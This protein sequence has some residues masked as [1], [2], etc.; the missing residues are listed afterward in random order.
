MIESPP[1]YLVETRQRYI[2]VDSFVSSDY[3]L[4]R[5]MPSIENP[6]SF[7]GK[8]VTRIGDAYYE[9]Q[10][11]SKQVL[12]KTGKSLGVSASDYNSAVEQMYL[13]AGSEADRLGLTLGVALT[14]DEIN[15]LQSDIIWMENRKIDGLDVLVP[16][17]YVSKLNASDIEQ[18]GLVARDVSVQ[19]EKIFNKGLIKAD[20]DVVV[21][22]QGDFINEGGQVSSGRLTRI[23]TES[24][25]IMN[26]TTVK[27]EGRP[28]NFT[29]SIDR[30]ASIQSEGSVVLESGKNI[31]SY[32]GSISAADHLVMAADKTLHYQQWLL[33][34]N[35]AHLV[36]IGAIFAEMWCIKERMLM[37]GGIL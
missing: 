3:F 2:D 15:K 36:E 9:R 8:K 17:V 28:G 20:Q 23:R 32:G 29:D 24:G 13:N 7:E 4:E 26:R 33:N 10:L 16:K 31:E 34:L 37:P 19:A 1:M 27:R 21:Q 12:Q 18:G 25:T 14:E 22:A 6:G 11:V 5:I 30:V 35:V